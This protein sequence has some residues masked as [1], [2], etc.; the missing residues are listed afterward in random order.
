MA[1]VSLSPTPVVLST[2]SSRRVPLSSN[3]NVANSPLRGATALNNAMAAKSRRS[4]ASTQR[5]DN[6]GQ[7]PPAK[8]QMLEGGT[9]AVLRSPSRQPQQQLQRAV[10]S[11]ATSRSHAPSRRHVQDPNPQPTEEDL[12]EI[13]KW[14][15]NQRSRFPK[16]VFYFDGIP[17]EQQ[18][19]LAKQLTHLGAVSLPHGN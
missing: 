1:A 9:K 8:R 10:P 3:P 6:Y 16:F 12:R 14:Q 18:S 11:R 17:Q 7:P 2:M 4:H 15:Q 19:R 13:R 5:E